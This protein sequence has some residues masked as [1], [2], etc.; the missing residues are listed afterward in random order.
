MN[1]VDANS[2]L[3]NSLRNTASSSLG[4]EGTSQRAAEQASPYDIGSTQWRTHNA[5][6]K[7][8][9]ETTAGAAVS[10]EKNRHIRRIRAAAKE[11]GLRIAEYEQFLKSSAG[12]R[13]DGGQ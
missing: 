1:P 2:R 6:G 8:V 4:A 10:S 3:E 11:L 9:N 7:M 13:Q 5:I 12:Q